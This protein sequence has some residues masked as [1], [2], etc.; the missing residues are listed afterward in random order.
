MIKVRNKLISSIV[1]REKKPG[2]LF[3]DPNITRKTAHPVKF[4]MQE[5]YQKTNDY[6]TNTHQYNIFSGVL[7]HSASYILEW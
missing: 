2:V 6:H 3:P 7:I 4:I 1:V 5:V